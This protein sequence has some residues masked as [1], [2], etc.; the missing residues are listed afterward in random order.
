MWTTL[1]FL[2]GGAADAAYDAWAGPEPEPE[3]EPGPP[4]R[5]PARSPAPPP[6]APIGARPPETGG[7]PPWLVPAGIGAGVLVLGLVLTARN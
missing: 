5:S 1:N 2:T 3:D 4:A 6:P 7:M